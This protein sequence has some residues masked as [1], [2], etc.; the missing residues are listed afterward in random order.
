MNCKR[1]AAWKSDSG[2]G[3]SRILLRAFA[4]PAV[5]WDRWR[6]IVAMATF[7]CAVVAVTLP[8]CGAAA[9]ST[10]N[11]AAITWTASLQLLLRQCRR[12]ASGNVAWK[13]GTTYL[14][15]LRLMQGNLRWQWWL[16]TRPI[17]QRRRLIREARRAGFQ[18]L[19]E[20]AFSPSR[21]DRA[22]TIK[23][24]AAVPGNLS[25]TLL[26]VLVMDS[27]RYVRLCAMKAFG[28]RSPDA[29]ATAELFWL[30]LEAGDGKYEFDRDG[31]TWHTLS[32][33]GESWLRV[34]YHGSRILVKRPGSEERF[35]LREKQR[36][37][38][39]LVGW[40]SVV[41]RG[42]MLQ[43][44]RVKEAR[45]LVYVEYPRRYPSAGSVYD[46]TRFV[47]VVRSCRSRDLAARLLSQIA[48]PGAHT[49]QWLNPQGRGYYRSR[50]TDVLW[51]LM[52]DAGFNPTD[53]G[54][55]KIG[56]SAA[57]YSPP[58]ICAFS[59]HQQ[60]ANIKM[61]RRWCKA[62][63]I[64]PIRERLAVVSYEVGPA[65]TSPQ[66]L[67]LT[68]LQYG[69]LGWLL[70]VRGM[71]PAERSAMLHWGAQPA[72]L[73]AVA[74]AFA[75]DAS[76]KMAAARLLAAHD[77]SFSQ[78]LLARLICSPSQAVSVTAMNAF[79]RMKPDA[80]VLARLKRLVRGP[81]VVAGRRCPVGPAGKWTV[82]FCGHTRAMAKRRIHAAYWLTQGLK[83]RTRLE[84]LLRHCIAPQRGGF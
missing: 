57:Q 35:S 4:V 58:E 12:Q 41:L 34:R 65:T 21:R 7:A 24:L 53:Y 13:N 51:V 20:Q 2:L 77:D 8:V 39:V 17:A 60:K 16:M 61:M 81:R 79:W 31:R 22:A 83:N 52:L 25:D 6:R 55:V 54:L 9:V 75:P 32:T 14:R 36:A 74:M 84:K 28:K 18:M 26:G 50:R 67:S 78:R 19:V 44:L 66:V 3:Q 80:F 43:M 33:R 45:D 11:K 71:P 82:K 72:R 5:M 68:E 15:R 70:W 27:S 1:A 62:H 63:S 49:G 59:R 73:E 29:Y 47:Q 42:L 37:T 23:R 30:A 38:G 10:G 48:G 40:H 76:T 64:K 69:L 46:Q 56:C